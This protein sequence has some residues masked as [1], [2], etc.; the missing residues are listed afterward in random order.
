MEEAIAEHVEVFG[1]PPYIIGL[2][3]S[4]QVQLLDGIYEAIDKLEPYDERLFLT[5]E[6]LEAYNKGELR[7]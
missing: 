3:W 4:E 7:F 5:P 1:V 6:D 2:Y